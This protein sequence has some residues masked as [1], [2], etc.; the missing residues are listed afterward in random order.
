MAATLTIGSLTFSIT[1]FFIP[2]VT[3]NYKNN[4]EM[5]AITNRS[6]INGH[7]VGDTAAITSSFNTLKS[8]L[9]SIQDV[10]FT[11][12][13]QKHEFL[14]K[15][16]NN[17]PRFENLAVEQT[18]GSLFNH[19]SFSFTIVAERPVLNAGI[20][21]V[22]ESKNTTITKEGTTET[23]S[24]TARGNSALTFVNQFIQQ[25]VTPQVTQRQVNEN[26]KDNSVTG[27]ITIQNPETIKK[28]KLVE[29]SEKVSVSGGF[30]EVTFVGIMGGPPFKIIGKEKHAIITVT[31]TVKVTDRN[32]L[33]KRL[34]IP[35]GLRLR[36]LID[37]DES[38]PFVFEFSA[39]GVPRI[40]AKDYTF[41]FFLGDRPTNLNKIK[42]R[43]EEKDLK[44]R[45][46]TRRF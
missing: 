41:T 35:K 33:P 40:F 12:D 20:V 26:I 27:I 28:G 24:I 38:P 25:F 23:R 1:P 22:E 42:V 36:D 11:I 4:G 10:T 19:I 43:F 39:P 16:H 15:D 8:L 2:S 5:I 13:G 6:S 34:S 46:P 44:E 32:I 31:G 30:P 14:L 18:K 3:F 9:Q 17:S 7:F 45:G 29:W 37:V 21:D